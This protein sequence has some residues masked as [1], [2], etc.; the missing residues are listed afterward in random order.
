MAVHSEHTKNLL[1]DPWRQYQL[2]KSSAK[3]NHPLNKFSTG[4]KNTLGGRDVREKLLGFYKRNYSANLMKLV[5]YGKE[6]VDKMS[7]FVEETFGGIPNQNLQ[8]FRLTELPF[9]ENNL[10]NMY[11]VVPI[12]NVNTV[13]YLWFLPSYEHEYK[14][15]PGEYISHL[16]GH[17]G[18]GSLLSFL[19]KEGLVL[20]LSSSHSEMFQLY[21]NLSVRL[22]LTDKGLENIPKI[23][24]YLLYYIEMMKK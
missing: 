1:S 5:V 18:P 16:L 9:D 17:E 11:K 22:S 21:S 15:S 20:S 13:E 4:D 7:R 10:G 23:T 8:P 3:E 19:K 12:K 14:N 2:L 24:G 6:D